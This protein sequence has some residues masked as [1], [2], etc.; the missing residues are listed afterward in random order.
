MI[1]PEAKKTAKVLNKINKL[2]EPEKI[3]FFF[4]FSD[5]VKDD[6]IAL[7]YD[8]SKRNHI[9]G[10][11]HLDD[12]TDLGLIS[13]LD[14]QHNIQSVFDKEILKSDYV[15]FIFGDKFGANTMHE[16]DICLHNTKRKPRIL[17]GLKQT[18]A[19]TISAEEKRLKLGSKY[20][21]VDCAYSNIIEFEQKIVDV[22]VSRREK[23]IAKASNIAENHINELPKSYLQ[24]ISRRCTEIERHAQKYKVHINEKVLRIKQMDLKRS[25][26]S[27]MSPT[28]QTQIRI[29]SHSDVSNHSKGKKL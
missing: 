14:T 27:I 4:C 6:I 12:W 7:H 21:I 10:E 8:L 20:L 23:R 16:W 29:N 1:T 3:R 17:L 5:D 11:L 18:S 25:N 22:L 19:N 9:I 15:V 13:V 24:T 2:L 28:S 26:N